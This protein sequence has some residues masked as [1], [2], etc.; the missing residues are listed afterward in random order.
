MHHE[1]VLIE[2]LKEG[3]ERIFDYLFHLYYSSLVVYAMK[4][5]ENHDVSE[6][7][8][9]DLFVKVWTNRASIPIDQSL[10][11]Y[12]FVSVRNRCFDW[13]RHHQIN[14]K[15]ERELKLQNLDAPNESHFLLESE[16]Q[17]QIQNAIDKLPPV[18]REVFVMNRFDGLKPAEIAVQK[19]ISVR[20][21]E[22]HIGKALRL[23]R[24]ELEEYLPATLVTVVLN[25]LGT[26]F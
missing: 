23:L 5:I 1:H 25:S 16:L 13:L 26:H 21:V 2:G 9:Q 18:C 19:G 8:V 22:T 20:T 10:K 7:I 6:D 11:S 4:F 12:F 15:T 14:L 3:N 24:S 17:Q